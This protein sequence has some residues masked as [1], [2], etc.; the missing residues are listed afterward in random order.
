M[1]YEFSCLRDPQRSFG[2]A[3]DSLIAVLA[4]S[5][6]EQTAR[7]VL[8]ED[9]QNMLKMSP[10]FMEKFRPKL[11]QKEIRF[12][13]NVWATP[14]SSTINAGVGSNA[15]AAIM[16]E[17]NFMGNMSK[18]MKASHAVMVMSIMLNCFTLR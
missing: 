1:F 7:K 2:L 17:S 12:P 3:P 13:N 11:T 4:I 14:A 8:F 5:L 15:I 10:Y 18:E 16:D 6:S 9:L